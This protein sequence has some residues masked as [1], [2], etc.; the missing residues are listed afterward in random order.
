VHHR[1]GSIALAG[2]TWLVL[3]FLWL[4][5]A[6]L[7]AY[8]FNAS[9]LN[10]RWGGF[11]LRWYAE[12]F[13]DRALVDA[14]F[15]SVIVA[16]W[17]TVISLPLGTAAAWALYRY[18]VRFA[19]GLN[20]LSMVPMVIPEVVMGVSLLVLFAVIARAGNQ[21]LSNAGLG[22]NLLG[23][24]LTT[25]VISHVTFCFPF[26]MVAIRARLAGLDPELEEAAMDLGATPARAFVRV[27]L[28]QLV[29][30]VIASGL[31]CFVLSLDELIVTYFTYGPG[32]MTLPVKAYGMARVGMSPSLNAICALFVAG[33]ALLLIVADAIRRRAA[34]NS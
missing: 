33:T 1:V 17:T 6:L 16:A 20:L 10:V 32:T 27:I 28:P 22:E 8:S 13:R 21:L 19:R 25:I 30:A 29:P 14:M 7:I 23:L 4:P 12:L 18:R 15:N 24:G 2:W 31:L 5:I 3:A 11:T 26:V 9:R 34:R